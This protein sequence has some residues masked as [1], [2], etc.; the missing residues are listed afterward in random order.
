MYVYWMGLFRVLD[1]RA[2]TMICECCFELGGGGPGS[3]L[4]WLNMSDVVARHLVTFQTVWDFGF[5][6]RCSQRLNQD[7]RRLFRKSRSRFQL[8]L[9]DISFSSSD[10]STTFLQPACGSL[11]D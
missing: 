2:V 8:R 1:A 3:H 10:L 4:F 11:P 6:A 7:L 9:S 5:L